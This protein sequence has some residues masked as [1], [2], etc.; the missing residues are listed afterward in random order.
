[1]ICHFVLSVISG[2]NLH[3]DSAHHSTLFSTRC[4]DNSRS[5]FMSDISIFATVVD[6]PST[7]DEQPSDSQR[8][9]IS[10]AIAATIKPMEQAYF[11]LENL[12]AEREKW[13][14]TELA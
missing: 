3:I 9:A 12:E 1:M 6:V 4:I 5:L 8:T 11:L 13:E 10:A 14:I 7:S 2:P